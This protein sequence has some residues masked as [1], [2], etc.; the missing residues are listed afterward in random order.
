MTENTAFPA[1]LLEGYD[2][3]KRGSLPRQSARLKELAE[4]G[5]KPETMIIACCDSRAA[6]ETIFDCAPGEIFVLR[7]VAN[8]V[9]PYQTDGDLHGTSAALEFAVRGLGVSNIVIMGH[10]SCG[11]ISAALAD[12]FEPLSGDD[13]VGKWVADLDSVI[14]ELPAQDDPAERQRSMEWASV[15]NSIENL[16][17]FPVIAEAIEQGSIALHGAWFDIASGALWTMDTQ[18]GDFNKA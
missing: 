17:A 18:T 9:P 7:N 6:P 11:G 8:L 10:A 15:R 3:F 1:R 5:Q 16:R 13:F 2:A 4:A 14:A 12:D